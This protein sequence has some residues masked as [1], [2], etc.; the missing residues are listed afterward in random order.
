MLINI[1]PESWCSMTSVAD[2]GQSQPEL[3]TAAEAARRLGIRPATLY[4]YVSRGLI[5]SRRISGARGSWFDP[6]QVEALAHDR[7]RAAR[8][9]LSLTI[10]TALT[11][12]DGRSLSYRGHDAVELSHRESFEAVASLLWTG[13]LRHEP[14]EVSADT[15]RAARRATRWLSGDARLADR[16]ALVAP[17]AASADPLRFDLSES[18]VASVG[19][20]LIA[21]MVHSLPPR[22]DTAAPVLS[23]RGGPRVASSIAGRLWT[24]LSPGP[25]PED[26]ASVLNGFLVML[27]DHELA[28][29]TL[30]A[31]V[32][33]STRANPY[34]TVSAALG[35]LDGP[36]HGSAS[37]DVHRLLAE[38]AGPRGATAAVADCLRRGRT[39]PGFGH[40]LYA[41]GDP[42]GAAGLDLLR[43]LGHESST[44]PRLRVVDEV[45]ASVGARTPA[46]PN[47]DFSLGALAFVAA[48]SSDAGEAI[49]AIARTAGWIAHT[50]EEYNEPPLRFRARASYSG[51]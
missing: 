14:F 12:I 24:R 51:P 30:A 28:T 19:R 39:V 26:A 6:A 33:A 9:G 45:L 20:V 34:A 11:R 3:I 16:L 2:E 17:A 49:F 42:R 22:S 46:S 36:L 41:D 1:N 47:S 23:V 50:L 13:Q 40:A 4:A 10:T 37:E 5:P 25:A 44:R 29:S 35:A 48:M 38:A 32:A 7:S 31:R 43:R 8:T 18:A 15:L 21:T 27:A